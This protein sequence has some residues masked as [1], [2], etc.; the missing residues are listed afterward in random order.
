MRTLRTSSSLNR[1]DFLRLTGAA[2]AAASLAP[3]R[4]HAAVPDSMTFASALDAAKAIRDKQ[5]SSLE[6][7]EHLLARNAKYH[8]KINA[9]V[10][11]MSEKAR[12][13]AKEA[14]AALAKGENWGPFH[15]VPITLKES[16]DVEGELTTIGFPAL[17]DNRAKADSVVTERMQNAGGVITGKTNVPLFLTDLQS[18]NDIYGTTNNPWNLAVTCGGSTGG[19][20]AALAAGLTYLTIGSDIGGS[21]RHP[22]HFCG[23]Y[24]HKASLNVIPQRG[25][26]PP[27]P[28][29]PPSP[30]AELP[31][32]GPLARTADD[33]LAAMNVL[34]GPEGADAKAYSWKLPPARQQ[35]IAD[36]R[37][38]YVLDDPFCPVTPEV[39]TRL[40]AAVEALRKA[41]AK[42]EE[43]WP[44]GVN[45]VQQLETYVFLLMATLPP[46]GSPPDAVYKAYAER[47]GQPVPLDMPAVAKRAVNTGHRDYNKMNG[48]RMRARQIWQSYFENHDAFLMP[49]DFI[50][51]F[52][53]DHSPAMGRTLK[54]SLGERP[55]F[56]L[57]YWITFATLTGLPATVAPTGLTPDGLPVGIQIMGPYMEDATPIDVAK[58]LA[59]LI[60]GFQTPP[61]YAS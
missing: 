44:E 46:I 12:T 31:V 26:V 19:G 30:P 5:V 4:T 17:K 51:A 58:Q 9:I 57:L 55:Y 16:F 40:E 43:G 15:G 29:D 60:G 34:G 3:S 25:H 11:D 38:G 10:V 7:T 42:V 14:D 32:L 20:A 53:H 41:G 45:P 8:E 24:G 22:A 56:D 33:L 49:V 1:R 18:Y 23:V 48:E 47:L 27:L 59:T 36:Y 61:G 52:P 2:I 37:I 13:R 35:R 39:R 50:P 21:I 6:L 28:T 54:T